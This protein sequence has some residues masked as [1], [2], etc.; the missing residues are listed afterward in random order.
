MQREE[1]HKP[2]KTHVVPQPS[3][4]RLFEFIEELFKQDQVPEQIELRQAGGR[5]GR[6]YAEHVCPAETFKP[7]AAKP[8]RE[9]LVSL[10]NKFLD[11]A[12]H[13]CDE[14]GSQQGYA[15]LAKHHARGADYYARFYFKKF[16]KKPL[17]DEFID[18]NEENA[19]QRHRDAMLRFMLDHAKQNDENDRLRQ[20]QHASATG[21]ILAQQRQIIEMLMEDRREDRRTNIEMMK[22]LR[23]LAAQLDEA[24]SKKQERELA[25]QREAFKLGLWQEGFQFLKGIIPVAVNQI[26]GKSTI[27][28]SESAE[29]I[30]IKEFMN[31][32][33]EAQAKA[34]FG[35]IV[36]GTI[37]PNGGIFTAKQIEIFV[38]VANAQAPSSALDALF[39][40][41]HMVNADQ[42]NQAQKVLRESQFTPLIALFMSRKKGNP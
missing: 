40:G 29:S 26:T 20:D 30:A 22:E 41:E 11:L 3:D 19:D 2:D 32:L 17:G 21:D 8:G 13:D 31:S 7:N 4:P 6:T 5:G 28:T 23:Q 18:E 10:A 9:K 36:D 27:P 37:N 34:L 14:L 33:D 24:Q 1:R 38:A 42:I 25:N 16:P 15:V 39:A 35:E 12:Q